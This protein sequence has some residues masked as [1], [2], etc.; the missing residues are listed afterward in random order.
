MKLSC[1][2]EEKAGKWHCN[3]LVGRCV[4]WLAVAKNNLTDAFLEFTG[5]LTFSSIY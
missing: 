1:T 4:A 3:W 2:I 5:S